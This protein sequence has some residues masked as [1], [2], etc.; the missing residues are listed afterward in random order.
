MEFSFG[1]GA[2]E[3]FA[4]RF[5]DEKTWNVTIRTV[6]WTEQCFTDDTTGARW[7]ECELLTSSLSQIRRSTYAHGQRAR[8][9]VLGRHDTSR[10]Q[11]QF[12]PVAGITLDLSP[13]HALRLRASASNLCVAAT[14]EALLSV[15]DCCL[16]GLSI[17]HAVLTALL[18][19]FC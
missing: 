1:T 7:I 9:S 4:I 17:D 16:Y 14:R 2:S 6:S 19:L 18:R 8:Q 10:L 11:Q 12:S 5:V 13:S 3:R 15:A